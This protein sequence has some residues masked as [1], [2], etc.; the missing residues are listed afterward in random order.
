ML[1]VWQLGWG[2]FGSDHYTIYARFM[3]KWATQI[4]KL[5]QEHHPVYVVMSTEG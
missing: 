1:V 2:G 3:A 5:D 4:S